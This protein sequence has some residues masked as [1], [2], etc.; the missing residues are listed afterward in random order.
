MPRNYTAE[1]VKRAYILETRLDRLARILEDSRPK[2]SHG[3][4]IEK[5]AAAIA[6][7]KLEWRRHKLK[8]WILNRPLNWFNAQWVS[9]E[10]A[11]RLNQISYENYLK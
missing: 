1:R 10:E 6:W 3:I 11:N 5:D 4:A 7:Q 8:C 9:I 2:L